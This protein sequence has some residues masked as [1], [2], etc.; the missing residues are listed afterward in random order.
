MAVAERCCATF[1]SILILGLLAACSGSDRPLSSESD[2]SGNTGSLQGRPL[3][4]DSTFGADANATGNPIGGGDGYAHPVTAYDFLVKTREELLSALALAGV[5]Q[6]VYVDDSAEIDLTGLQN[7]AVRGSLTL[8]SGRGRDGSKGA[9]L[10]STQI[11]TFPL[12][13]VTGPD[14][15]ITGLRIQGPDSLR[16]TEQMKQLL[17]EGRYYSIPNSRG[18]QTEHPRLEVDNCELWGWS[19]AAIFLRAGS[20][21]NHIHH[22]DIHHNQRHGLGYG[23]VLDRSNALI[24]ANRF[25]WCRHHIA[26]TGR[27][28][29]GYEARYNL[30]LENANSH[31]FDMHGGRDREDGTDVAGDLILIHHNTFYAT[32]VEAVVIRGIPR[33]GAEIYNNWFLHPGPAAAIRQAYATGNLRHYKNQYTPG[34]VLGD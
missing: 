11:E 31:S 4:G 25:D 8:A 1:A 17:A 28:G 9:R 6:V 24:E 27:P 26:G 16:R 21:D 5:G 12:F 22:N 30:V 19:H 18:I 33:E 23:V 13:L 29:T 15:R 7:I 3:L 20:T 14:V 2:T 10:F 32:G 34:R